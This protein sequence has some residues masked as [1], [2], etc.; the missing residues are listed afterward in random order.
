MA[1]SFLLVAL[2]AVGAYFIRACSSERS[3]DFAFSGTWR[4][5]TDDGINGEMGESTRTIVTDGE[6]IKMTMRSNGEAPGSRSER[7]LVYDGRT[8]HSHVVEVANASGPYRP[9]VKSSSVEIPREEAFR[10]RLGVT[11]QPPSRDKVGP[12]ERIAGRD[13]ILYLTRKEFYDARVVTQAWMD[14]Q[15]GLPLKTIVSKYPKQAGSKVTRET[16][17]CIE[18]QYG[19]VPELEFR[20]PF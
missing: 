20:K 10:L 1:K 19:P 15:S 2:I 12:G 13:T 4:T 16:T 8:L 18:I 7:T 14:A 5:T 6:R 11:E 9:E 17:E 3:V